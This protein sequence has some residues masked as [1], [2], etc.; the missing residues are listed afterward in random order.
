MKVLY[1]VS[2]H[3]NHGTNSLGQLRELREETNKSLNKI[4]KST[5]ILKEK[6]K[7]LDNMLRTMENNN[8]SKENN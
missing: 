2:S 8:T 6:M 1:N 3:L 7:P 4:N 5:A